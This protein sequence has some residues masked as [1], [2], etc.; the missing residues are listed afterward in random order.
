MYQQK[1]NRNIRYQYL[2]WTILLGLFASGSAWSQYA[3]TWI[4]YNQSYYKFP[5][6]SDGVYRISPQLQ[7][8]GMQLSTNL[9][10]YSGFI[11]D[12]ILHLHRRRIGWRV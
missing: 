3:N 2:I 10:I 4:Q 5:V 1:Q 12:E 11:M 8:A 9:S 7:N 6:V